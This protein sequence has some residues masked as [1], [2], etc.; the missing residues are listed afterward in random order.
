MIIIRLLYRIFKRQILKIYYS[1]QSSKK[2]FE[3]ME[4]IFVDS[5][6]RRY[7]KVKNDFDLPI[8]RA[9][10]LEKR[11]Q[12]NMSGLS[13]N[14]LNMF[15]KAMK[16]ALNDGKKPD[17]S[18]IG[19]LL[20]EM[21]RRQDL[22]LHED[23]M[24]D[25]VAFTLIREDEDPAVIDLNIHDEKVK[26]FMKDSKEGLFD[27]FYRAGLMEYLPYLKNME[28]DW[29]EYLEESRAK[30]QAMNQHLNSYITG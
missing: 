10:E 21:E 29:N 24:F 1:E 27:F 20:I 9:K 19:H 26:Q 3:K 8:L 15:I 4:P 30:I 14:N 22:L 5:E 25:I 18:M 13:D 28:E 12:R 17:L 23:I 7:F 11:L 6:G 2:G 16:K